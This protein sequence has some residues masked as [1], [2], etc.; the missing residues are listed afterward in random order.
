MRLSHEK[1]RRSRRNPCGK[2]ADTV[3]WTSPVDADSA[4]FDNHSV[5]IVLG[6]WDI[7][8]NLDENGR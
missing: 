6:L 8:N 1:I 4:N 3:D 7:A 5:A 2:K